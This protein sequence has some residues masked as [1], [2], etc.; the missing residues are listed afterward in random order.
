MNRR[1]VIHTTN[2]DRLSAV[3]EDA[4]ERRVVIHENDSPSVI[5]D[6]QGVIIRQKPNRTVSLIISWVPILKIRQ[7]KNETIRLITD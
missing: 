3:L 4:G 6:S 1:L 5:G 7:N 2:E